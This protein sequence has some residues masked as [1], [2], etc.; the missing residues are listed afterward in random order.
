M[1]VSLS[2]TRIGLFL[3]L[4]LVAC[5]N[6]FDLSTERG[7]QARID[8]AN[9]HLSKGE[10]DLALN[11]INPIYNSPHVDDEVRLVTASAYACRAKFNFLAL[12]GN[13]T[14]ASN[15]FNAIAK[16]LGNSAGDGAATDIYRAIDALSENSSKMSGS[17]RS[18]SINNYMV[19]I[20]MAVVG[21]MQ[22]NYGSPGADGSQGT[23]LVYTTGSNPADEM[24][25]LDACALSA[26]ISILVDSFNNSSLSDSSTQGLVT[27]LNNMCTSAGL[28]SCVDIPRDR[29]ACDGTNANS[30]TAQAV[31]SEFN[32]AW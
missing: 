6:R 11:A 27:S 23:N 2:R 1:E 15:Y 25:N 14:G 30:I 5:G 29:T 3:F 13:L 4:F 10:C 12:M 18:N 21:I 9:F 7:R 17:Q 20:Q 32:N 22:R 31:I 19:F 8:D 24:S 28:S 26:S 16:S